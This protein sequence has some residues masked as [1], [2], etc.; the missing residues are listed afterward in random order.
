[1]LDPMITSPTPLIASHPLGDQ[2]NLSH[3]PHAP[4]DET[5]ARK[6]DHLQ[7]CLEENV[8]SQLTTGLEHYRFDHL[9]LPEL[10]WADLT[11]DTQFLNKALGA[12]FLISSMTGGTELAKTINF[13][14]AEIAQT[15]QLAMGVGSQRVAIE[16]P[17]LSDSFKIRQLAP[18]A[19]LFANIG[20][21]Q[22]NYTYGL[23]E[24]KKAIDLLEADA[25]ILHL[26]PLQEAVQTRGDRNFKNIFD[27]IEILCENLSIPVIGKE[28]GNGISG[29]MAKRLL[30]CGIRAIDVAGAGG[31]SWAKVEGGR[32]ID[33]RQKRL[34][35]TFGNWGIPTADCIRQVRSVAK[36]VPLIASGGIRN[37]LEAAKCLAL[38]ADLVGFAL[39]FLKAA[40]ESE[41]ALQT[42]TEILIDELKTV[43]F[44][45]GNRDLESFLRSDA[46]I[47]PGAGKRPSNPHSATTSKA[48]L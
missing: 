23:D 18:D 42:L 10:D 38:G 8:Q 25:L 48:Y 36:S 28:V 22:L 21:V 9:C 6:A 1:M 19:L 47:Y 45:T 37:G 44:C 39:P 4:Q 16:R 20:A 31:T 26:N 35:E 46:L 12:P 32:A 43:L 41:L 2:Q 34:G 11:I 24:C 27:Q 30:D 5:Q 33:A 15:Y 7:V 3:F 13:R 29:K 40:N 17:D 14:L